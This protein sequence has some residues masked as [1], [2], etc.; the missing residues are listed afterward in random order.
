VPLAAAQLGI[1]NRT[2]AIADIRYEIITFTL[3]SITFKKIGD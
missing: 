3:S 1:I 2:K